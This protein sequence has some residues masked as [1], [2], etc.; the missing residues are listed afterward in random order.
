MTHLKNLIEQFSQSF[1]QSLKEA[2][3]DIELEQVRI[4][5]LGRQG[6]LAELMSQLKNLPAE[7]KRALGPELNALKLK[8]QESFQQRKDEFAQ[9]ELKKTGSRQS[10]FDVTAYIRRP[11]GSLHP[12]TLITNMI[13]DI[14]ISMGFA[15]VEGPEVETPFYNFEALN[16][17]A[18]H[19]ARD[20]HDTLWLKLTG[21]LMRTHT[22]SVQIHAMKERKPPFALCAPGRAYRHE[23]TDATHDF[24]FT[25]LEGL[26]IDK[27]LSVA[28]LLGTLKVFMQAIFKSHKIDIRVRPSYFPFVEPGLEVDVSCPF[29]TCGCSICKKTGWIELGGAGMVHPN[30]LTACD[31]DPEQWSGFAWGMGIERLAMLLYRIPDI[32]LFK[33]SK[34]EFLKQF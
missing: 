18:D 1:F 4:T 9:E 3:N 7:E 22:S 13:E 34:L 15:I 11:A 25:Q 14:F 17:P 10:H 12:Y 20:T 30:V 28:N 27:N 2:R 33:S 16:I 21:L 5:Y 23:A 8:A 26:V 6:T 29:C 31:I 32:R 24:V 19:P